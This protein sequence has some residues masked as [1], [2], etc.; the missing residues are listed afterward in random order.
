MSSI[1]NNGFFALCPFCS[2]GY[3]NCQESFRNQ[4]VVCTKCYKSFTLVELFSDADKQL[5]ARKMSKLMARYKETKKTESTFQVESPSSPPQN[6]VIQCTEQVQLKDQEKGKIT[7][8]Q[9]NKKA[10]EHEHKNLVDM[11]YKEVTK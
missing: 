6:D 2:K 9:Q 1:K 3:P 10:L 8:S 7:K 11:H 4:N 5:I